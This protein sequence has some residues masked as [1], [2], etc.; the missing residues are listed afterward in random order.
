MRTGAEGA[1]CFLIGGH[2]LSVF[3]I[4]LLPSHLG[5]KL[6]RSDGHVATSPTP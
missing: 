5:K 4:R 6:E 3:L 1:R 2:G